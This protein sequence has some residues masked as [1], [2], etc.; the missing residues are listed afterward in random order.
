M[1]MFNDSYDE[2]VKNGIYCEKRPITESLFYYQN[3]LTSFYIIK[4]FVHICM[5]ALSGNTAGPNGLKFFE[6]NF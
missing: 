4:L 2:H 6:R 1:N 5:L 3:N